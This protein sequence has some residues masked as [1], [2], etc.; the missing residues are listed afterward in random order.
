MAAAAARADI[1]HDAY[2]GL[3][4]PAQISLLAKLKLTNCA[5]IMDLPVVGLFMGDLH[6]Y[7]G[8]RRRSHFRAAVGIRPVSALY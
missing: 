5:P 2:S 7:V 1:Q 8:A 3:D 6:G 4:A